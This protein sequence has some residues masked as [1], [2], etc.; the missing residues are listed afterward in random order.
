MVVGHG[1]CKVLAVGCLCRLRGDVGSPVTETSKL[2]LVMPYLA[3]VARVTRHSMRTRSGK[4]RRETVYVITSLT[5]R[6]ASPERLARL[7]RS[8]WLIE[9]KLHYV[10]DV[11][12]GEDSSQVRTGHGLQN[13]AT[14][15]IRCLQLSKRDSCWLDHTIAS[16]FAR[17]IQR[18][19]S[20]WYVFSSSRS[21]RTARTR[22][23]PWL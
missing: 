6:Q 9:N 20:H 21:V 19:Y 17:C 18:M 15:R 2:V 5:S 8:Q 14:P 16:L 7:V 23:F 11:A 4:R 3:Q 22:P 1:R 12:Y 13:I 10:R